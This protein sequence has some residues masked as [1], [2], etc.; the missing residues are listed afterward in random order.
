MS[1]DKIICIDQSVEHGCNK[2]QTIQTIQYTAMS[3]QDITKVLNAIGTL[4]VGE[5]KIPYLAN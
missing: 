4:Y 3:R 5:R 1:P 2:D